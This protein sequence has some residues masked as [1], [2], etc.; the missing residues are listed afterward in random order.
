MQI[1]SVFPNVFLCHVLYR[2]S[3]L[4]GSFLAIHPLLLTLLL[5]RSE[6]FMQMSLSMPSA[7]ILVIQN[8]PN[9]SSSNPFKYKTAL[10][11]QLSGKVEHILLSSKHGSQLGCAPLVGTSSSDPSQNKDRNS[12]CGWHLWE[13]VNPPGRTFNK[14]KQKMGDPERSSWKE[15][16]PC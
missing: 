10:P 12:A 6:T 11:G 15:L 5:S 3:V 14:V 8:F 16:T 13:G 2:A 7:V 1:S 9:S 4:M